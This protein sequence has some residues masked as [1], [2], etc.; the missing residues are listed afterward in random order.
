MPT[1]PRRVRQ[2]SMVQRPA[3]DHVS[4][5]LDDQLALCAVRGAGM[6]FSEAGPHG[7]R[8][9]RARRNRRISLFSP[10]MIR[11][12]KAGMDELA[13]PL[14]ELPGGEEAAAAYPRNQYWGIWPSPRYSDVES[15]SGRLLSACRGVG[16]ES[17]RFLGESP[18]CD[19]S[20]GSDEFPTAATASMTVVV[21]Q[22]NAW[23]VTAIAVTLSALKQATISP[24]VGATWDRISRRTTTIYT[25]TALGQERGS[26]ERVRG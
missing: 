12:F 16:H 14:C 7:R 4:A 22:W 10:G 21:P 11:T 13:A 2:R 8:E 5:E 1:S 25:F 18:N 19:C 17:W 3:R 15:E 23:K 6:G 9:D 24:Y 20:G 26:H